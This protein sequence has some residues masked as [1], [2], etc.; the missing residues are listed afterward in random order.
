MLLTS[1][2]YRAMLLCVEKNYDDITW[3]CGTVGVCGGC[4]GYRASLAGKK[5]RD[6]A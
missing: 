2:D 5:E 4:S 1:H 6:I 3:I